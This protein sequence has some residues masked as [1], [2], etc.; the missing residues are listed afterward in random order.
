MCLF[1]LGIAERHGTAR[2]GFYLVH[3]NMG[4][5]LRRPTGVRK[6]VSVCN[7]LYVWRLKKVIELEGVRERF[8]FEP[9]DEMKSGSQRSLAGH[10]APEPFRG[11]GEDE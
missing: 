8:G 9:S 5:A 3:G 10:R 6:C 11:C 7:H 2:W 4:K 1:N